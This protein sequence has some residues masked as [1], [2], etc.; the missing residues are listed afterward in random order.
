MRMAYQ[1][2]TLTLLAKLLTRYYLNRLESIFYVD[3]KK[4]P[5]KEI[6]FNLNAVFQPDKLTKHIK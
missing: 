1:N 5:P 2:T 4:C 3:K 6:V